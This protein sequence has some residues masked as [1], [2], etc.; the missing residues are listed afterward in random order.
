[1][2]TGELPFSHSKTFYKGG[3]NYNIDNFIFPNEYHT[4]CKKRY[5]IS[6]YYF[7]MVRNMLQISYNDRHTVEELLDNLN[8]NNN[9]NSIKANT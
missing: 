5:N 7:D 8:D 9:C 6:D 2:L 1:M 3:E 4:R